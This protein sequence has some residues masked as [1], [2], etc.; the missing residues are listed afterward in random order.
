MSGCGLGTRVV[1]SPAST[2]KL[3]GTD[4]TEGTG[5]AAIDETAGDDTADETADAT[6]DDA[7]ALRATPSGVA[8]P[9]NA[10]TKITAGQSR[11]TV[12]PLRRAD[13]NNRCA[14]WEVL[15]R[16]HRPSSRQ[17]RMFASHSAISALAGG[18]RRL[19]VLHKHRPRIDVSR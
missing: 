15:D 1:S 10:T 17:S 8:Q 12:T 5:A 16:R 11:S 9:P 2:L 3:K 6:G 13:P 4:G 18:L 14:C 19:T 7:T